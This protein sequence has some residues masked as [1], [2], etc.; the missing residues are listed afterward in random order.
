MLEIVVKICLDL[1]LSRSDMIP[2]DRYKLK[3]ERVFD[4]KNDARFE[5]WQCLVTLPEVRLEG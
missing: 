3:E 4:T 2:S 1:P 5:S